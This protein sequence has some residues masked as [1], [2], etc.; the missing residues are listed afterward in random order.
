[1]SADVASS[2][3]LR[4]P[5]VPER[6]GASQAQREPALDRAARSHIRAIRAKPEFESRPTKRWNRRA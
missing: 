5:A 4:I 3:V 2:R 1:M 6:S